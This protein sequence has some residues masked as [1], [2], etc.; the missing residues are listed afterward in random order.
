[1]T[2]IGYKIFNIIMNIFNSYASLCCSFFFKTIIAIKK[3]NNGEYFNSICISNFI[4]ILSSPNT[5]PTIVDN[6]INI[7]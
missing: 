5:K 3:G 2:K 4:K 1:M 6:N 7:Y